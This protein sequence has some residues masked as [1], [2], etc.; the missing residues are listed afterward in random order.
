MTHEVRAG[1]QVLLL[2][3]DGKTYLL[4]LVPGGSFG[5]HHGNLRHDEIV[6]K[7]FGHAV[8]TS[9]GHRYLILEPTLEDRMMKVKRLTQIIYPK[10][11]ALILLKTGLG[12]G[13]RVIECGA[14]S[15]SSS[16]A[17]ANA[18]APNGKLYVYDRQERF[19]ENARANL[20]RAGLGGMVE[21][22]LRDVTQ[23]F[24]E[25]NVDAVLLDLPSPWEGVAPARR[26]LRGGGRLASLSPTYNQIEKMVTALDEA[27]FVLIET[28]E[29]FIRH[30][31]VREGKTRPFE[32]VIG[33]TGFL[34]F[35]R[36]ALDRFYSSEL[37]E[38]REP[39]SA[40]IAVEE[41]EPSGS[42]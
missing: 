2:S 19:L 22:R 33:H 36:L 24:D 3:P 39:V 10:D 37:E 1:D 23:G 35:A 40:S 8:K 26:A 4:G 11:A 6:G 34:T 42:L 27:G 16:M 21:Y 25:K 38:V 7:G 32:R 18:L 14:G 12:S 28:L 5:T 9:L 15:G 17:I 31:L 13:M 29:L 30:I 41:E 20:D